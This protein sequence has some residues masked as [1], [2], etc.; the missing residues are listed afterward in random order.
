MGHPVLPP[1][2][3]EQLPGLE[4]SP[5][6]SQDRARVEAWRG[7]EETMENA[8]PLFVGIDVSK[9]RLDVGLCPSGATKS[10]PNDAPGIKTLVEW[11]GAVPLR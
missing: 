9:T 5:H 6:H 2:E 1:P 7:K 3:L 4:R 11:L 10:V 8:A